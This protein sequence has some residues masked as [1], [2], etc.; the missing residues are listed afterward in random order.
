MDVKTAFLNG[1]L[2]EEIYM[3]Q[4]EDQS[5]YIEK[6]LKKYN[7]FDSKPTCTPYDSSVKLFKNTDDSVN[8]SEYASII[9]S[10]RYAIDCTRPDIAYVVGLLCYIDADWNS[11][12]DD[13]KAINGYI[14]NI[15]GGAVAWKSKKQTILA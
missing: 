2:E 8:Q 12:S 10:L 15:V 11:L 9:G 1:D 5:H 6:I 7:Y 13:S 4:L 3:E 14:V